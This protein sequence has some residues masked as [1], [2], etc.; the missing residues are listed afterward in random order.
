MTLGLQVT[1][2]FG[3]LAKEKMVDI[4]LTFT[5]ARSSVL[6]L[7]TLFVHYSLP[8]WCIYGNKDGRN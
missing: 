5:D 6:A 3:P 2:S 4:T 8:T 1:A 7:E